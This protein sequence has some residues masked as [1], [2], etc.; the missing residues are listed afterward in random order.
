[1]TGP[2]DDVAA[3][4]RTSP[5]F[6]QLP[7]ADV[8]ALAAAGRT[9]QVPAGTV[10]MA[11]GAPSDAMIVV[12]DGQVEV[13]RDGGGGPP[14]LLNVCTRGDLLGELGVMQGVPRSATV[15]ARTPALVQRIDTD[16]LDRL[17]A[18]P[19][20]AR[21]LLQATARRLAREEALLRQRERMAA[22]GAL[23][24]GLL[25][26]INNPAAAVARSAA[27]LRRLLAVEGAESPLRELA[28]PPPAD[29]L[30]RADAATELARVLARTVPGTARVIAEELAAAGV[31]ASALE[32]ALTAL[33]SERRAPEVRRFLRERE[34]AGLLEEL[35]TG[36]EHLSR[37]VTGV[38]PL[39]YSADQGLTEVDLHAGLAQALVL[40]RHKI[41]PGVE[42]VRDLDPDARTVSGRPADLA[43][44][45][46]NL[47]DNAVAAVGDEGT[48]TIR[49]RGDDERVV[50]DVEN[51]GP[52]VPPEVVER[53][54]DPFFTTKP[55]GVGTGLGL[56]T[57]LAVVAQ[58]HHGELTLT[59][60]DG[61]TRARVVLP[62]T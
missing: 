56:T 23:T 26:E 18:H 61:V 45:W 59:S 46:I 13:T 5:L 12:L 27:R 55:V 60:A 52:P 38:R 1:M 22:L 50:V 62:R 36:A 40:V 19:R 20:S 39:A 28:G 10:L 8:A 43:L 25:H 44:V 7:D 33:P 31:G 4:L 30:A 21:A 53:A 35:A 3:A 48:I 41:P 24:A 51:T 47:L 15:R 29:S 37:I 54:F 58:Q 2:V 9:M 11:E 42:V 16:A 49:T 17:L 32:E 34:I 6:D 57:S 14:V